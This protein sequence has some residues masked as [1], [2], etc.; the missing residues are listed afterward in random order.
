VPFPYSYDVGFTTEGATNFLAVLDTNSTTARLKGTF[1]LGI[2]PCTN[3]IIDVYVANEEGL[4][5]GA[6]FQTLTNVLPVWAQ[7]ESVLAY[8]LQA[9]GPGDLDAAPGAFEFDISPYGIPTGTKVTA[10]ASY[11]LAGEVGTYMAEMHTSRFSLPVSL[12]PG[13]TP[14]TITSI[15]NNGNDTVT[16]IWTGGSAPYVV[17]ERASL[18]SGSWSPIQTNAAATATVTMGGQAFFRVK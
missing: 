2:D 9:D 3:V 7:G 16:L 1:Q 13:P 6:K 15:V 18:S 11:A 10:T 4:T 8:N 5:N 14:I 12:L 17:E